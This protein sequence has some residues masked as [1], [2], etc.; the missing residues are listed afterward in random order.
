M[1]R[2][3]L[4]SQNVGCFL[5][6][7]IDYFSE[8]KTLNEHVTA[9]WQGNL[10]TEGYIWVLKTYWAEQFKKPY[11]NSILPLCAFFGICSVISMLLDCFKPLFLYF[12]Q[13]GDKL[14][15]GKDKFVFA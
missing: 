7:Q 1:G 2:P 3:E 13:I 14:L 12:I 10:P 4:A 5:G 8:E 6:L 11:Y 9:I 15:Q